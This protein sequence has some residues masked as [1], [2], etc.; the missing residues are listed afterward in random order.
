MKWFILPV[1]WVVALVAAVLIVRRVRRGKHVVLT[2]RFSPRLIRMIVVVLV[3]LGVGGEKSL[4]KAGAFPLTPLKDNPNDPMPTLP[5]SYWLHHHSPSSGW[6]QFKKS[7][8][9]ATM[10]ESIGDT[11]ATSLAA[12]AAA[13]ISHCK[14]F[15]TIFSSDLNAFQ[16]GTEPLHIAPKEVLAALDQMEKYGFYD[17]WLCAHLWRRTRTNDA[18]ESADLARLYA[19]LHQHARVTDALIAAHAQVRPPMEAPHAWMSKAGPRPGEMEQIK[20]FQRAQ[21]DVMLVAAKLY[22]STDE[23]T[24]KRD[25]LILLSP[26]KD[27]ASPNVIKAGKLKGFPEGEKTRVGRLDLLEAPKDKAG[28]LEHEWLGRIELPA[29]KTASVWELPGYLSKDGVSKLKSMI[30]K[31]LNGDE[32]AADQLEKVLPLAHADLRTALKEVPK[33]KGA[34]RMRMILSLFDDAIMP[35]LMEPQV[36]ERNL[37]TAMEKLGEF[38]GGNGGR[39]PQSR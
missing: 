39:G 13:S 17:H 18:S 7:M 25:G 28:I 5:V 36:G 3:L 27:A 8:V 6:S 35:K 19:R 31:A 9:T 24:W 37:P 23:G 16:K 33:A 11:E 20:A 30:D 10:K 14:L 34:S 21:S 32:K 26:V 38:G 15:F 12:Q 1:L 22:P 29:G 2:G 4:N